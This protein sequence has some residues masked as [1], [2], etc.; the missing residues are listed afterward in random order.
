MRDRDTGR[1]RGFGFVTYSTQR[2]ADAAMRGLHEQELDGRWVCRVLLTTRVYM[3]KP[4]WCKSY[5]G[6]LG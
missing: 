4:Y 6:Q 5:Q 2:E 3:T 1:A